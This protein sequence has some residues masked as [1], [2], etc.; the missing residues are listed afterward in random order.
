MEQSSAPQM[1][2]PQKEVELASVPERL[3]AFII[4]YIPFYLL[5]VATAW[6]LTNTET[7]FGFSLKQIYMVIFSSQFLFLIY[8]V[9]FTCGS[10]RT[11]G[12][13]LMG[14]RVVTAGGEKVTLIQAV[15]RAI[16]YGLELMTALVG[17]AIAV[18]TPKKRAVHD[19]MAGTVVIREREKTQAE[20]LVITVM[21]A[22]LMGLLVSGGVYIS[23][24]YTPGS[25]QRIIFNAKDQLSKVAYLQELHKKKYGSYTQNLSRLAIISGDPVQFQRDM[26]RNLRRRGFQMG[27]SETDYKI[28]GV[29]KDHKKTVVSFPQ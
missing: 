8:A 24:N 1:Q 22:L 16:G 5:T 7:Y 26:Q 15:A 2:A 11:V 10:R 27:I 9:I 21:G 6:Y 17:F 3:F 23:K 29:A 14:I 18:V 12:K 25:Q 13:W 20:Q 28:V 19:F 4:D